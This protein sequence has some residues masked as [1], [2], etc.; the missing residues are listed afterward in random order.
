MNITELARKLKI[1]TQELKEK[2]PELG[3]HIGQRA[4]QIPDEQ[5][6]RVIQAWQIYKKQ[7]GQKKKFEAIK[8][9][10]AVKKEIVSD[11]IITLPTN[12]T[13]HDLAKKIN[14]PVAKIIQQLMNNGV[15]AT[16]NDRLDFEIAAI[17]LEQFGYKT[18]KETLEE[19]EKQEEAITKEKLNHLLSQKD[20][21][22][23]SIKAPVVVVMGHIDHGKTTLLDHIRQT[24]VA[25]SEVG[26]ITQHIGA[27]EVVWQN[28]KITFIDTPGH[29]AFKMMR[30]R[31]GQVADIAI[32]VVAAD[33]GIKEQTIESIR[34]I[35][36]E[37]LP[38]V[39]AIN[40]IDRSEANS[41]KIK[42]QLAELNVTP[43][44][45]GGKTTCQPVSA[46]TGQGINELL[47]LII[48]LADLEKEKLL[49][50][51]NRSAVGTI[52]EAHLDKGEGPVATAIIHTGTLK[53]GDWLTAGA[54]LG[55]VKALKNWQNHEIKQ[56]IAGTPVKIIGFKNLPKI[57]DILEV[58]DKRVFKDL[59]KKTKDT[60]QIGYNLLADK[61]NDEQEKK[62]LKLIIKTDVLGS[63][64]ALIEAI[65]KLE[66]PEVEIKI[67]KSGLG[68]INEIDV[69]E[70]EK[71]NALLIGF[72][73]Q[74]TN[75]AKK[76]IPEKGIK[77]KVSKI[78]YDLLDEIKKTV[79]ELRGKKLKEVSL[80][81]LKI[82]AL[83]RRDPHFSVIG[84]KVLQGK[85]L[86]EAKVRIWRTEEKEKNIVGQGQ[87]TELQSNRLPA[88]EV[89]QGQ[90]CGVKYKGIEEVKIND[91]FEVYQEEHI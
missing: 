32:L 89:Q 52:I 30:G 5:A 53:T 43:E 6:A 33:D 26:A 69:V 60:K 9:K 24:Q 1:T 70:T 84:G 51:L 67:I 81:S 82:L 16:I 62:F 13:V 36:K 11:K 57:G 21:G 59:K 49:I 77:I 20:K 56:A 41:E 31:G 44:E 19:K 90:E 91:I 73:V 10:L 80:G 8:E 50:N 2:L 65:K 23:L 63:L 28:R 15:M 85:I 17:I 79:N 12:I 75:E 78:I 45:W 83:F 37:N 64:E 7:E 4:I 46:K 86:P 3:F 29:E 35:Q 25:A 38:F 27:Y 18:K 42:K 34:V 14:L 68:S 48:V 74:L 66:I 22:Q 87:I 54:G 58:K 39:V 76:N 72:N 61:K 71:N 88:K 55:K 40:K 47:D